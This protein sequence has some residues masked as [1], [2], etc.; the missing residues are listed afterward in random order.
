MLTMAV[1][2]VVLVLLYVL[3]RRHVLGLGAG[4]K[5]PEA[6]PGATMIVPMTG[7]TPGMRESLLSLLDQD[8]TGFEAIFVTADDDDPAVELI[9]EIMA[10]DGRV[11]HVVSG[12][13]VRC[14]QKNHNLLAGIDAA[15]PDSEIFMFCDS[16]HRA[17]RNFAG[18]LIAPI[19]RGEAVL[20]GGFHKVVPL[21]HKTG[22]LGMLM[23]CMALHL[24]QPVRLITQPWGGAMAMSRRAFE[25]HGIRGLWAENIVDDFSLGPYMHRRK[26]VTR[27]VASACLETPMAGRT[28]K[29]WDDWLFRQLLYLKFCI[30]PGWIGAILAV[31]VLAAPPVLAALS[32]AGWA[33]GLVSGAMALYA[34]VFAALF[35]GFGL[36]YRGLSPRPVP[37]LP[38]LR[39]F[40]YTFLMLGWSF[41][42]TFFTNTMRWRGIA[43]KVGWGGRVKEVIR[44][45]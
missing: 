37:V 28:L 3:G 25:E 44:E 31:W 32:L 20:S 34:G 12:R 9:R 30:P 24:M 2:I 19:A 6:M 16:T 21:D 29:Q 45:E 17:R 40:T 27:E 36:L 22:T 35:L 18:D 23:V 11:R 8:W 5:R 4:E 26:I 7:N 41:G 38:W 13:A 39:A 14:G 43:Y 15:S 33:V 10:A 42:R 1:D